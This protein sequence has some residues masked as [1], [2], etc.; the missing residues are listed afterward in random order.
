MQEIFQNQLVKLT[1]ST[2]NLLEPNKPIV[3]AESTQQS[4]LSAESR[5]EVTEL[6]LHSMK[7][8]L[9]KYSDLLKVVKN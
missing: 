6:K 1:I 5:N 7:T 4:E 8:A 2:N 9:S 3:L